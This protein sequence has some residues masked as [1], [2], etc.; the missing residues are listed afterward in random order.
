MRALRKHMV[1][2]LKQLVFPQSAVHKWSG[3][4]LSPMVYALLE[5]T[6]FAVPGNS[7]P[8]AVYTQFATPTMIKHSDNLFLRLQKEHQS[9]NNIQRACFCM[10]NANIV[11][12]FKVSNVPSL[13]GWNA[14]M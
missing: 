8:V 1:T 14:S 6:P 4:V 9:Y 12:H 13:I 2:A 10:L 3:M 7:G 11:D 5:P